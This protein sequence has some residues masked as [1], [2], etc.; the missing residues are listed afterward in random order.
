MLSSTNIIYSGF[1]LLVLPGLFLTAGC[2]TPEIDCSWAD[3]DIAVDGRRTDWGEK[4][5]THFKDE[6]VVI[7][8]SNDSSRLYLYFAFRNQQWARLIKRGG[9]TLWFD[10][11]GKKNR[12]WGIKYSGGPEIEDSLDPRH[13]QPDDR[14]NHL[15]DEQKEQLKKDMEKHNR[16]MTVI[17][18]KNEQE[19][20]IEADGS[21]GPAAAFAVTN[22]IYTYEFEIPLTSKSGEPF[23]FCAASGEKITIGCQW[24]GLEGGDILERRDGPGADRGGGIPEGSMGRPPGRGM[25]GQKI[26]GRSRPE[27]Q[28]IWMKTA[29]VS[30]PGGN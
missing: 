12:D 22:G 29:L 24:S 27:K 30:A 10:T 7:G 28:E 25:G 11:R 9:L 14:R 13:A 8:L 1:L 5:F 2:K 26:P 18:N 3:T 15:T 6:D 21:S 16:Q 20:R 4:P 17:D 23:M 19:Y